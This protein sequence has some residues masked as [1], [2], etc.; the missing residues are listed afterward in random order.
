MSPSECHMH[1]RGKNPKDVDAG[2]HQKKFYCEED[3][4]KIFSGYLGCL[5]TRGKRSS[6]RDFF[7]SISFKLQLV[8]VMHKYICRVAL[9]WVFKVLTRPQMEEDCQH[10]AAPWIN[11]RCTV[12][13]WWCTV[14]HYKIG[15]FAYI[16]IFY[17]L[18]RNMFLFQLTYTACIGDAQLVTLWSN[19]D[20]R[21][22][23]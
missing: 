9:Q 4:P 12:H 7:G 23:T 15:D 21:S 18:D 5:L 11:W 8:P 13:H 10:L 19:D 6:V 22:Q 14:H 16:F 20:G 17:F 2:I 3:V 1:Q